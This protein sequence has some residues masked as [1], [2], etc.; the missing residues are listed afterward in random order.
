[1]T[2]SRA[3]PQSRAAKILRRTLVGSC[4][5]LALSLTL[6]LL[7]RSRDGRPL[8]Y[9]VSV[10]LALGVV[11]ASRMGSLRALDLFPPLAVA[12]IGVL[13]L[14][15]AAIRD[16]AYVQAV[17][18]LAEL[19]PARFRPGVWQLYAW[20]AGLAAA[21][22]TT[23]AVLRSATSRVS[24]E[25]EGGWTALAPR[26][27]AYLLFGALILFV[28]SDRLETHGRLGLALIVTAVLVVTALP[29]FVL[30]RERWADVAR[31]TG[32]ALWLVPALP[33]L[34]IVWDQWGI[35]ALVSLLVLSKI[36]DTA[37]YYV[38]NA[39]G[40][41]HPF[42]KISP[43]KTTAGCVGSLAAAT[44]AGGAFAA[45]G[46][47]PESR[48]GI[49]A[50]FAAGALTNVAA[51]AGDLLESWIKRRAGVKDSSTIFGPSGGALDQ[52]D[53]LLLSVPFACVAWRAL[54]DGVA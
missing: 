21:T 17:Y 31:I 49:A 33:A 16:D 15:D 8:F 12:A 24:V 41:T 44:L 40:R 25:R 51:Q 11:E 18:P 43:G 1:M 52:I 54:F 47:L 13:A 46:M 23:L 39:I 32:L 9:A 5:V 36:G 10:M 22:A 26:A 28:S 27:L 19:A 34:W 30:G 38:G 4:L 20:A 3:M 53:S 48:F 6:W 45:T 37:G 50:G 14:V 7:S 29:L 35:R 42:P 2:Q